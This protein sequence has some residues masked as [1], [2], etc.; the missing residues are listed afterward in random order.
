VEHLLR[1]EMT[2]GD[3][4]LVEKPEGGVF[5]L[6]KRFVGQKLEFA[7]ILHSVHRCRAGCMRSEVRHS[8]TV[9][10]V[11]VDKELSNSNG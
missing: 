6:V 9:M 5:D 7:Q 4:D 3:A 11:N 2:Q 10:L 8:R 1:L